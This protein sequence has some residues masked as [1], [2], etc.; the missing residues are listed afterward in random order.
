M[1]DIKVQDNFLSDDDFKELQ[2]KIIDANFPW[3]LDNII[4]PPNKYKRICDPIDNYQHVHHF[5]NY[6]SS[7]FG[8]TSP[9]CRILNP[10]IFRMKYKSFVRI[11]VNLTMKT[12]EI[13]RHGFHI[14]DSDA[15]EFKD[16]KVS[17]FYV[18]NNDGY[19]EFKDGTRMESVANRLITFP[20]YLPHTSTT[21]TDEPFRVVINFNYF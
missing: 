2:N 9:L 19:T 4:V 13:V 6:Y 8:T 1:T 16:Y 3:Y 7:P 5:L 18:N 10:I 21:C 20:A 11:K 17:I 12:N 14:D 15:G